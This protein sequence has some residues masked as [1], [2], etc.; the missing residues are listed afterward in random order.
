MFT[1]S[2]LPNH[3]RRVSKEHDALC[4][5]PQRQ[6]KLFGCY[7]LLT[8]AEPEAV[9]VCATG[10]TLPRLALQSLVTETWR[11]KLKKRLVCHTS[12]Q[13]AS[14]CTSLDLVPY[15]SPTDQHQ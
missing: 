2:E 7:L 5:L 1:G 6:N 14:P 9:L 12:N 15:S 3:V 10:R 13:C 4:E 11:I 8:I